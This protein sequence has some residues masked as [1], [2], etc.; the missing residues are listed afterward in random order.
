MKIVLFIINVQENREKHQVS[1]LKTLLLK[2]NSEGD[3]WMNK[4]NFR[5]TTVKEL[6]WLFS[7]WRILEEGHIVHILWPPDLHVGKGGEIT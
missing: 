3:L 4:R 2:L 6:Q 7:E 5:V 1:K